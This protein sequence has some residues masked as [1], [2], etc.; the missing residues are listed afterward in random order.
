MSATT[1]GYQRTN[2]FDLGV[3][4]ASVVT[5]LP[6]ALDAASCYNSAMSDN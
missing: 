6:K 1:S 5:T 2:G 3:Q 4:N